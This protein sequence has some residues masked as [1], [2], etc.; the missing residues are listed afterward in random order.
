MLQLM[1]YEFRKTRTTK[2]VVV[3]LTLLLQIMF[4]FGLYGNNEQWMST[5]A[6]LLIFVA[7]FGVII[8]GLQSLLTLH[9]DMSTKQSYMLFM[10]PNSSYKI[11]GAKVL[12]C[13]LSMLLMAVFFG[14]L[15]FLDVTLLFGKFGQLDQLLEFFRSVMKQFTDQI[16]FTSPEIISFCGM[17]LCS[18]LATVVTA[19]FSDVFACSLL[20][21]KKFAGLAAF[22]LFVVLN[23]VF[24]WISGLIPPAGT[25]VAAMLIS[26]GVSLIITAV[27]YFATAFMMDRYLSV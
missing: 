19:A 9:K 21:G 26:G 5:G 4:M 10:T 3:G 17:L 20:N 25:F 16:H 23:M 11:L 12:E 24:G 22:A 1:K 6:G 15:G 2:L 8:I 27:M 18:W 7:T 14:A 13:S